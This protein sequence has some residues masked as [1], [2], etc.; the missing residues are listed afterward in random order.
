MR[1][2]DEELLREDCEEEADAPQVRHVLD[3][4]LPV[5][6]EALVV[7][8]RDVHVRADDDLR[9]LDTC[10]DVRRGRKKLW[11]RGN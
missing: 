9:G 11:S 8:R 3:L 4:V 10:E 7:A 6:C 1:D 2:V 5:A